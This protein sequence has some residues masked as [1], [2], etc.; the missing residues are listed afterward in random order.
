MS[1]WSSA[2][3]AAQQGQVKNTDPVVYHPVICQQV[4]VGIK[5]QLAQIKGDD[6]HCYIALPDHTPFALA[7]DNQ[8]PT[9][10]LF[11]SKVSNKDNG[12][13]V[14]SARREVILKRPFDV[15]RPF[16]FF[17][18]GSSPEAKAAFVDNN[19][20]DKD[21]VQ[22]QLFMSKHPLPT[23]VWV[24]KFRTDDNGF[25]IRSF[26]HSDDTRG[27]TRI[28]RDML[29]MG[30]SSGV[31]S[32]GAVGLGD[33]ATNQRFSMVDFEAEDTPTFTWY[34]RLIPRPRSTPIPP[35]WT[36]EV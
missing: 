10:V 22:I 27:S 20:P 23:D 21:L 6:N 24:P 30:G 4:R 25:S 9:T 19:E 17:E 28:N 33:N 1:T 16:V 18:D 12:D 13:I 35:K 26:G 7:L 2:I 11:K 5:G 31:P 3:A 14:V 34:L 32:N 15:D 29:G 8:G 36:M